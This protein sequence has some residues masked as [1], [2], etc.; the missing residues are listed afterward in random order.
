MRKNSGALYRVYGEGRDLSGNSVVV[1]QVLLGKRVF[2]QECG[3]GMD[4]GEVFSRRPKEGGGREQF[5]FCRICKPFSQTESP[6]G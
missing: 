3:R 1:C 4:Q 6:Y 5:S 2:C